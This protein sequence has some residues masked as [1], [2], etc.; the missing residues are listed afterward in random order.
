MFELPY[1]VTFESLKMELMQIPHTHLL[2]IAVALSLVAISAAYLYFT[3]K[4]KGMI[5]SFYV[6]IDW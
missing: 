3:K 1:N 4:P 2:R 5:K 6:S